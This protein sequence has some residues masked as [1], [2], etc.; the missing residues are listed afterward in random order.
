MSEAPDT[1]G[2]TLGTSTPTRLRLRIAAAQTPCERDHA[3]DRF[4][5]VEL[6]Q[7]GQ[8][9]YRRTDGQRGRAGERDDAVPADEY[10]GRNQPVHRE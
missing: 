6:R 2:T 7:P 1:E 3:R 5:G 9:E 10:A 8:C 4:G